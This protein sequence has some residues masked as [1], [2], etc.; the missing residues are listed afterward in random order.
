MKEILTC[1][2]MKATD[3]YTIQ[4]MGIPSCV[5]MERAALAVA[6]E[7]KKRLGEKER[8]LVV[9]GSGN[10]G[11]DGIAVAR[12]LYLS[13]VRAEF[14]L[15][16]SEEKMTQ[17]TARQLQIARN[18]QVPQVHTPL[19]SEYTTIVDAIFGVGLSRNIEGRY[20][21][22]IHELNAADA[23]RVAVDIPSGVD[24]D[25][26]RELGAVFH[27]DLTVTFAYKKRGLCFY[28]GRM[29]AGEIVTAD[30]GIYTRGEESLP[31]HMEKGDLA[32]LPVPDPGGNKG[33]FGRVLAVA[34]SPGMCG[35]AFLCA[36]AA[37]KCGAG[38]VKIQ[39]TEENRIPLQT[40]LP[41][42]M[43]TS[44][45]CEEEN[46]KMMDWCDVLIIGPGLGV[47]GI[48][49]KR[50]QWF[51]KAAS[52]RGKK[53]IL[54]ADGLNLLSMH[55]Q[56]RSYLGD[57]V[58]LTPHPGEMSRLCGSSIRE[59]RDRLVD[60][61]AEYAGKTGAACVLKDACTVTAFGEE[62]FLNL[63]GNA[64]MAAAGSG[65]VL[66]GVEAGILCAFLRKENPPS[67]GTIAAL[68]AYI[69]GLA[70]DAAAAECGIRGMTAGDILQHLPGVLKEAEDIKELKKETGKRTKKEG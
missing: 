58:I 47:S 7:I 61:A 31:R 6:E 69:H 70:G 35:A 11:G 57:H 24:G 49:R 50:A 4:E 38:M 64:G 59:I 53:V 48:S 21:E 44:V 36:A 56:W 1:S 55:P 25:T 60:T 9:C 66:S 41:E 37:L 28:P 62:V 33:T 67:M 23:F 43:V 32:L 14:F 34:G 26:G 13:G 29:H 19:F 51:L 10:N 17:E 3:A 27:A 39:T 2:Q 45:F 30:I 54:D 15:A 52:A 5:L 63:S 22:L 12:L 18:Y 20:A 40:L 68:G 42:A 8:I 46:E 65:D 16:G